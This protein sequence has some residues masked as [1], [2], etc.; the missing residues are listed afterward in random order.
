[1]PRGMADIMHAPTPYVLGLPREVWADVAGDVPVGVIVVD[2]DRDTVECAGF[3]GYN[4]GSGAGGGNN[5][6]GVGAAAGRGHGH[7][8]GGGGADGAYD[9]SGTVDELAALPPLP[10]KQRRK[11]MRALTMHAGALWGRQGGR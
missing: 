2:L 10:D 5:P 6:S 9:G 3:G 1:M 11:L 8:G 4:R 7:G